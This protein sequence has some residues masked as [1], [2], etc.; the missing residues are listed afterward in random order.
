MLLSEGQMSDYKGAALMLDAL[1]RAKALL[2]DRG[3]DADWFR[4]ALAERGITPCIP[5]KTNRKNTDPSRPHTL[6][7]AP[8][9]REHVRQAQGLAAHPHPLRPMRSHLLLGHLHRRNRHLLDQSMSPEPRQDPHETILPLSEAA[10]SQ[11]NGFDA[12]SEGTRV[13]FTLKGINRLAHDSE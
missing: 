11:T 1:P 3:Y 10:N 4:D 13:E 2:G 9:D 5:S 7:S 8:Q 12:H 6:P